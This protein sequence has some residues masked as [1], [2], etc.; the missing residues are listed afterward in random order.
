MERMDSRTS[1]KHPNLIYGILI[2]NLPIKLKTEAI[3]SLEESIG[4]LPTSVV[5]IREVVPAFLQNSSTLGVNVVFDKYEP[6]CKAVTTRRLLVRHKMFQMYP[7]L[8]DL[9]VV[10]AA[11]YLIKNTIK[12]LMAEVAPVWSVYAEVD[13]SKRRPTTNYRVILQHPE[14]P[15]VI[16]LWPL[17]N[18]NMIGNNTSYPIKFFCRLCRKNGHTRHQCN[19]TAQRSDEKLEE[20]RKPEEKRRK[21]KEERRNLPEMIKIEKETNC[22]D[23]PKTSKVVKPRLTKPN[24]VTFSKLIPPEFR[25]FEKCLK[26]FLFTARKED[27]SNILHDKATQYPH[28]INA[29]LQHLY[30]IVQFNL[31]EMPS[32]RYPPECALIIWIDSLHTKIKEH[33]KNTIIKEER[34]SYDELNDVDSYEQKSVQVDPCRARQNPKIKNSERVIQSIKVGKDR[35][36]AKEVVQDKSRKKHSNTEI[37]KDKPTNAITNVDQQSAEI[38]YVGNNEISTI[39]ETLYPEMKADGMNRTGSKDFSSTKTMPKPRTKKPIARKTSEKFSPGLLAAIRCSKGILKFTELKAFLIHVRRKIHV[40]KLA[41]IYTPNVQGLIEQL[42]DIVR[43]HFQALKVNSANSREIKW[44][45]EL[46]ERLKRHA[47]CESCNT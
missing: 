34:I 27:S 25:N 42:E 21:I 47:N 13:D 3:K 39:Q 12:S 1:E 45:S 4:I 5:W 9:T 16:K 6:F 41:K 10:G 38:C 35:C 19:V 17:L 43:K 29:L 30:E 26:E 23:W 11:P 14:I 24:K 2:Q 8:T 18:L 44:I 31:K 22:S 33:L 7:M 36:H 32:K 37:T 46:T 40:R 15:D 20:R 28:G